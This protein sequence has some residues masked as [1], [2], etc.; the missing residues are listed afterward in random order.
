MRN[1][2]DWGEFKVLQKAQ[3]K[4]MLACLTA[5]QHQTAGYERKMANN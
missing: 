1:K 3:H 2:C 5:A 4:K